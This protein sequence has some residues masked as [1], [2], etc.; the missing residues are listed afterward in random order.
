VAQVRTVAMAGPREL[1]EAGPAPGTSWVV[2]PEGQ[3][4][5]AGSAFPAGGQGAPGVA[6]GQMMVLPALGRAG[7]GPE[8]YRAAR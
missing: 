6:A 7:G 1:P 5:G 8:W 2:G 4:A 3:H